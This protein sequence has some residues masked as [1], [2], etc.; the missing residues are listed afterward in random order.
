MN[1][2][3][4]NAPLGVHWVVCWLGLDKQVKELSELVIA[5]LRSVFTP[6]GLPE[7]VVS[8]NGPQ[9][10]SQKSVAC[11]EQ[12]SRSQSGC[13]GHGLTNFFSTYTRQV[14]VGQGH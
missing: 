12:G 4:L 14:K 10:T 1:I 2:Q 7:Q 6:Y 9:F 11:L 5:V 8:D 3:Q 13:P